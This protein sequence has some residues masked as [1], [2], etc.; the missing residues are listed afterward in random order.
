[1][2]KILDQLKEETKILRKSDSIIG[3]RER[4]Q[5]ERL[6]FLTI[7]QYCLTQINYDLGGLTF[8]HKQRFEDYSKK[9]TILEVHIQIIHEGFRIS[10]LLSDLQ[11]HDPYIRDDAIKELGGDRLFIALRLADQIDRLIEKI[12]KTL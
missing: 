7:K 6:L 8:E 9:S 1:M 12:R 3:Y 5:V 2:K 11:S 10:E 4:T